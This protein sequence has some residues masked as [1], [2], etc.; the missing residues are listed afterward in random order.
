MQNARKHLERGGLTGAIGTQKAHH[1]T[2][3]DL[4]GNLAHGFLGQF[5]TV[6]QVL[7]RALQSEL[8]FIV[9][10]G[11]GQVVYVDDH[12]GSPGERERSGQL[13]G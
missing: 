8:F 9:F 7:D 4:E 12:P 11:F 1:F 13:W 10:E 2:F 6:K 5:F 3:L